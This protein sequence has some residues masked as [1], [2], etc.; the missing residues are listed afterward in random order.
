[1]K[2]KRIECMQHTDEERSWEITPEG[3]VWPCCYFGNTWDIKFIDEPRPM[4]IPELFDDP[5]LEKI[6]TEDPDWNSLEKH[7]LDEIVAHE[8]YWTKIWKPGFE[9]NPH[10]ICAKECYVVVDEGTG[11]ERSI[12]DIAIYDKE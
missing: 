12:S 5:E 10:P 11:K 1:M 2:Y 6:M 8:Y 4:G 7:S 3:R 9:N